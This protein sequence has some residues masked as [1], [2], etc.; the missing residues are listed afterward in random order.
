[1][2]ELPPIVPLGPLAKRADRLMTPVM[3]F[4]SG[5]KKEAPQKTHFWNNRK[6]RNNELDSLNQ[7]LMVIGSARTTRIRL[8]RPV[9]FHM[10]IFGG[11]K[12]YIV[13]EPT[14]EG[15]DKV[16]HIGWIHLDGTGGVSRI[17][18]TGKV[19]MLLGSGF[20]HFFGIT[21]EGNQIPIK[22][23]GEGTIGNAPPEHQQI[24][25]L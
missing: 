21:P 4:L 18:I 17:P 2:H 11:W 15:A 5:T 1:M 7:D 25:L 16:W 24:P 8:E 19:R 14:Q 12:Y 23:A 9:R 13:L 6:F 20:V 10:P 22:S 3:I